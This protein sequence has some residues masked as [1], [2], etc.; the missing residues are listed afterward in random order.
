M[1]CILRITDGPKAGQAI[2]ARAGETATVGRS[3]GATFVIADDAQLSGLH[4]SIKCDRDSCLLQDLGST[5]KTFL[6]GEV[7]SR[8]ALYGGELIQAGGSHFQVS[9]EPDGGASPGDTATREVTQTAVGVQPTADEPVA[10]FVSSRAADVVA[11]FQLEGEAYQSIGADASPGDVAQRLQ[12]GGKTDDAL[13]F[14]AYA[15]PKRTAVWWACQCIREAGA[16]GPD[17]QPSLEAAESWAARPS[18]GSRRAAMSAAEKRGHGT[19]ACWAATGAFWSGG[20]M[21]PASAPTVPPAEDLTGKAV[22]GALQMAAVANEPQQ[23]PKKQAR[24][25]EIALR[26]AASENPFSPA[27]EP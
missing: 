15:F 2:I 12:Q 24:F 23:A 8:K 19:S 13:R 3:P 16:A 25:I 5:N 18:E 27:P 14:L 4:F 6:N 21:A 20:S 7:V 17:D 10:G 1:K 22:F 26:I 9:L 11:H